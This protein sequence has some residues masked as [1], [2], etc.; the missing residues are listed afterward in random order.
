MLKR[1][2][3]DDH[4]SEADEVGAVSCVEKYPSIKYRQPDFPHVRNSLHFKF[5]RQSFLINHLQEAV[6]QLRMDGHRRTDHG[7]GLR[8]SSICAY[9]RHLRIEKYLGNT[10]KG[11]SIAVLRLKTLLRGRFNP[12]RGE[13]KLKGFEWLDANY[14]ITTVVACNNPSTALE[15]I[16]FNQ[17]G[18]RI[19]NPDVLNAMLGI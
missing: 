4:R 6:S 1:L 9:L 12:Q 15:P 10:R 13:C 16:N 18:D 11:T 8:I 7:I 5:P 17:L 19:D 2:Q 3:L 14:V